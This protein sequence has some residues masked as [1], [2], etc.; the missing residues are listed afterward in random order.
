VIQAAFGWDDDH[1]WV[2]TTG[3][4][5]F[6]PTPDLDHHD[7]ASACLAQIAGQ[8]ARFGYVFD[9]G[10]HWDHEI[11]VEKVLPIEN[12]VSYPICI[13]GRQPD[14]VQ[15]GYDDDDD[16]RGEAFDRNLINTRLT[17]LASTV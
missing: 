7:P 10:D 14:P 15:Y 2:F 11:T 17:R 4:G 5:Q 16:L 13:G 8:G 12:A 1:L 6:G 3:H 9:F